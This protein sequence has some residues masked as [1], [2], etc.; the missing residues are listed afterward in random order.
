[1]TPERERQGKDE[2]GT[3]ED[4][5]HWFNVISAVPSHDFGVLG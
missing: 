2:Q 4:R 5:C 1:M 3:H